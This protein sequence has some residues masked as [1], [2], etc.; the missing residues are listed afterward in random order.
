MHS[1]KE[2]EAEAD[3]AVKSDHEIKALGIYRDLIREYERER[4]QDK[5]RAL[6]VKIGEAYYSMFLSFKPIIRDGSITEEEKRR[7]FEYAN[8]A[9]HAWKAVGETERLTK[10]QKDV[11]AFGSV[12]EGMNG[13]GVGT[14]KRI[15]IT[16]KLAVKRKI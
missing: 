9:T 16:L 7:M 15:G 2:R 1:P 13:E 14:L 6:T 12:T 3:M 8:G 11:E 5:V 4:R 10:L